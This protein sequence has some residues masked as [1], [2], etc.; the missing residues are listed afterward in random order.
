MS[1]IKKWSVWL[2]VGGLFLGISGCWN[3]EFNEPGRIEIERRPIEMSMGGT[4]A[5]TWA[6]TQAVMSKFPI[7][8]RDVDQTSGRAYIVTDW[9]RGKS[10]I[11]YHGFG[12]NRIPY[13]IR[14]KLYLTLNGEVRGGATRIRIENTE[15]YLDDVVTSGVD[16]QGSTH[17]W[18][19]TESSTLK[20]DALLRQIQKLVADPKF[21][22]EP[23]AE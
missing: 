19:R 1:W 5:R 12:D 16:L 6:A 11:L 14:Y 2:G 23:G 4:F 22:T 8:K 3:K 18:I 7:V 9:V 15:Q 17:T 21:K 10:D 20:E 13:V